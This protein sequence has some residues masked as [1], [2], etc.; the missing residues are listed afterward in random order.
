MNLKYKNTSI[1]SIDINTKLAY[2]YWHNFILPNKNISGL[3]FYFWDKLFFIKSVQSNL[4]GIKIVN[5]S[6]NKMKNSSG[7]NP[8]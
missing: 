8:M 7:G 6:I 5:K 1:K 4:S 2:Y 3:D